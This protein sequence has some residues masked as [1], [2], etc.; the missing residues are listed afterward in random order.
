LSSYL[1][2]APARSDD[3]AAKYQKAAFEAINNLAI[4]GLAILGLVCVRSQFRKVADHGQFEALALQG[5][6]QQHQPDDE[7]P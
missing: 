1:V 2:A 6:D 4:L 7:E 5:F 3:V